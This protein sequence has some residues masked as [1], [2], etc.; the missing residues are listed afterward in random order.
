MS[1]ASVIERYKKFINSKFKLIICLYN[2]TN[3][4]RMYEYITCLE[5]NLKNQFIDSIHIIYDTSKDNQSNQLLHYLQHKLVSISFISG[6]PTFGYCFDLANSLYPN[7]KIIVSNADIYF[8]E[9]LGLI[10]RYN[11]RNKFIALTR[12]DVQKDG[13]LK[14]K[15]RHNGT[16]TVPAMDAQDAWIFRT[17]IR[18]FFNNNIQL[19]TRGCDNLIAYQAFKSGLTTLNPSLTIQACH[20]HLTN[21][22]HD[23]KA[24]SSN[25]P[26]LLLACTSLKF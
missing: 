24:N 23:Q 1:Y 3:E 19:G 4:E 15:Q 8:N 18:T 5:N 10:F 22:R 26:I 9:T 17:P 14:I 6:R 2:E 13:S 12:W 7:S 21:I 11:L 25:Q 20:L 16:H